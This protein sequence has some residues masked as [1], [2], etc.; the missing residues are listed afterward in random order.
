MKIENFG[1]KHLCGNA[2]KRKIFKEKIKK[3]EL[4]KIV[5]R[6]PGPIL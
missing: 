2:L 5:E 6:T 3:L 1:V 4:E